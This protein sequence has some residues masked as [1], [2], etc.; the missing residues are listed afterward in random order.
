MCLINYN[1]WSAKPM[2]KY[3]EFQEWLN[4]CPIKITEYQDNVSSFAI[5]FEIVDEDAE[6][7][8]QCI[9]N[10]NDYKD[11]VDRMVETM[12]EYDKWGNIKR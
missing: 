5:D 10:G 2:S 4:Q 9:I 11:C 3:E 1:Q 12:T 8:E 7:V 6:E